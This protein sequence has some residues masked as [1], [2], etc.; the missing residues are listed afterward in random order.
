[1]YERAHAHAHTHIPV[2][3]MAISRGKKDDSVLKAL[4]MQASG[5]EFRFSGPT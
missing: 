5:P 2:F 3:K 4:A 1:M